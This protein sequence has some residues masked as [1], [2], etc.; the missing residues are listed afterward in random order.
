MCQSTVLIIVFHM[1]LLYFLDF[2]YKYKFLKHHDLNKSQKASFVQAKNMKNDK[3][4]DFIHPQFYHCNRIEK[5][6]TKTIMVCSKHQSNTH[7]AA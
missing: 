4:Q 7:P 1:S 6:E 5:Y 2:S 3:K